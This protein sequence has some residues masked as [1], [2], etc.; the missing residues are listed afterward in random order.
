VDRIA[1]LEKQVGLLKAEAAHFQ[2]RFVEACRVIGDMKLETK[3]LAHEN[4]ELRTDL[5]YAECNRQTKE[6]TRGST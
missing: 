4:A 3:R 5:G 6:A 2:A 1:E